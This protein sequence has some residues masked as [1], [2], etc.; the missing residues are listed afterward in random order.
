DLVAAA[1]GRMPTLVQIATAWRF[2]T[3]NDQGVFRLAVAVGRCNVEPGH[4]RGIGTIERSHASPG[5]NARIRAMRSRGRTLRRCSRAARKRLGAYWITW[6]AEWDRRGT[7]ALGDGRVL[8]Q[9][10]RLAR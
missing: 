5:T 8:A 4:A 1:E 10:Q 7:C 3:R 2:P 6:A 9:V